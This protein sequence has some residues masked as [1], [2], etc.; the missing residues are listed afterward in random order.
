M[1]E[2]TNDRNTATA[3]TANGVIP[4]RWVAIQTRNAIAGG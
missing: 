2:V 3:W 4:K 1:S